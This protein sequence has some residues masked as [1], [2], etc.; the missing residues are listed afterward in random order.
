MDKQIDERICLKCGGKIRA[1]R[2]KVPQEN[3]LPSTMPHL[4]AGFDFRGIS[5]NIQVLDSLPKWEEKTGAK[6]GILFKRDEIKEMR[7]IGYRCIKCN[8]IEIYATE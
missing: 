2:I 6:T 4:G 1:G 5:S 8:Y 3:A 7:I